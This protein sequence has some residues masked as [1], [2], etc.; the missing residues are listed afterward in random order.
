M[1]DLKELFK[2]SLADLGEDT[3]ETFNAVGNNNDIKLIDEMIK[4][5]M[6]PYQ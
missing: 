3:Y 2:R 4:Q 6:A 1:D 5:I